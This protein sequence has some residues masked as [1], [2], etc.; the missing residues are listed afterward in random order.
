MVARTGSIGG[1]R[2]AEYPCEPHVME[3]I[4]RDTHRVYLLI[5]TDTPPSSAP[6]DLSNPA[7]QAACRSVRPHNGLARLHPGIP[8]Q[9]R[10]LPSSSVKLHSPNRR[11]QS[12]GG[13]LTRYAHT[14]RRSCDVAGL[15][16]QSDAGSASRRRTELWI[17]LGLVGNVVLVGQP[18]VRRDG[19]RHRP[20]APVHGQLRRD[21]LP[22]LARR[23]VGED[24]RQLLLPEQH[25]FT[26][27]DHGSESGAVDHGRRRCDIPRAQLLDGRCLRLRRAR[28]QRRERHAVVRGAECDDQL[29][30]AAGGSPACSAR[31]SS[32]WTFPPVRRATYPAYPRLRTSAMGHHAS[33]MRSPCSS[34]APF[35]AVIEFAGSSVECSISGYML[36]AA[37]PT[38]P[39]TTRHDPA[40]ASD[41]RPL[42]MPSRTENSPAAS[43]KTASQAAGRWAID[44]K[45]PGRT[46]PV[47]TDTTGNSMTTAGHSHF[48]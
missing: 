31:A 27:H 7:S 22:V 24:G 47:S 29:T 43:A 44:A 3:Q 37:P 12:G 4:R 28:M 9:A 11:A 35:A 46:R 48:A 6:A 33:A 42:S 20:V 1:D 26:H 34:A 18:F 30:V 36:A 41:C 40:K 19:D 32:M 38:S 45:K 14:H 39:A 8:V 16:L 10:V 2:I 5:R 25:E 21:V 13:G 23:G 17:W 15:S